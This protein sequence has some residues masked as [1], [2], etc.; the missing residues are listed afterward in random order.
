M[1]TQMMVTLPKALHIV[2]LAPGTRLNP[3]PVVLI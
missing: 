2:S 3:L 1:E